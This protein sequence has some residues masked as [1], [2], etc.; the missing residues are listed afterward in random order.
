MFLANNIKLLKK[1]TNS[2]FQNI[3][4]VIVICFV[5]Y[6]ATEYNKSFHTMIDVHLNADLGEV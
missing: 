5:F 3:I 1:N 4:G 6:F 2:I